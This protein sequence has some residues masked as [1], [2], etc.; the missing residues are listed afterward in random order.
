MNVAMLGASSQIAK[1]LIL[2]FSQ[3]T[4]TH[5]TLFVRHISSLDALVLKVIEEKQYQVLEY[6]EFT[7]HINFDV[8]LNFVG[9]GDPARAATMGGQIFEITEHYDGLALEYIQKHPSCKYIFL[10][11]GAVYGG[12]FE[13]PITHHSTAQ[14]DINQLKTTDW[15]AI[16]KVYAEAKHRAMPHHQIIDIRVFN[17][18]SHTLDMQSR[19]LITD[20]V[21][22]TLQARVFNTSA[23]NITRDFITPTDFFQLVQKVISSKYFLNQAID[24]Y[25]KSPI[26]KISLLEAFQDRFS[27]KYT[28]ENEFQSLNATGMKLNYYSLNKAP[29]EL[30][31]E[32]V[33]SSLD[34]L[35][36]EIDKIPGIK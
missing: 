23:Q 31:Y 6:T 8:I 12:Q 1:D 22:A 9:V 26:D 18:F 34:G 2:S 3:T 7:H 32:P 10:S 24:C 11:S 29:S 20:L 25:T 13:T 30:V 5:L 4:D 35:F 15:Y 36:Y 19:F 16:A 21:R 27:L 14:F 28:L 17:Y 33:F